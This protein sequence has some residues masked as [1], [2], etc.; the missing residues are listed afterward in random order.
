[1]FCR[2]VAGE[3]PATVVYETEAILAFRDIA[4]KAPVHSLVITKAHHAD[5][6]ALARADPELASEL[7]TGAAE[8]AKAEGVADSGYRLVFNIGPDSGQEVAHVH[9]HVLGGGRLGGMG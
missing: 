2:I 3:I 1:L 9:A 5:L 8:V 6:P 7:L 4:P